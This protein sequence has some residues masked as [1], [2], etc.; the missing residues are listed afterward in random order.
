MKEKPQTPE[1]SPQEY[2]LIGK[3]RSYGINNP[4]VVDSLRDW[5]LEQEVLAQEASVSRANIELNLRKAKLYCAGLLFDEAWEVLYDIRYQARREN[6]QDLFE[7]A[8]RIMSEIEER[9]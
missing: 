8:S 5:L 4:D 1:F 6:E 9:R 2:V 3:L 7:E